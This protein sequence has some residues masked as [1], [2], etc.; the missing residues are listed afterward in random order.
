MV[1]LK[2]VFVYDLGKAGAEAG[3]REIDPVWVGN[4]PSRSL[5]PGDL[6]GLI[7]NSRQSRVPT[8]SHLQ[9]REEP[10]PR[11]RRL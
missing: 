2:E 4:T 10:W 1:Y 11:K 6:F 3:C 8:S 9:E 5:I 7:P